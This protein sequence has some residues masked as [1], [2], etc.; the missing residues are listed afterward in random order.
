MRR[1]DTDTDFDTE[2]VEEAEGES[3]RRRH[4][5]GTRM[6]QVRRIER[7]GTLCVRTFSPP[8]DLS[9]SLRAMRTH[10]DSLLT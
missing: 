8:G 10:K 1:T 9:D 4:L 2:E 6:L 5:Q 3:A 7:I